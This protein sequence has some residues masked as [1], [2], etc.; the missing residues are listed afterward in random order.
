MGWCID[1]VPIG[2]GN[3]AGDIPSHRGRRARRFAG[4]MSVRLTP[5]IAGVFVLCA[6]SGGAGA[7]PA[8]AEPITTASAS[9]ATV[10]AD[11]ST[12]DALDRA[13]RTLATSAGDC[14]AACEAMRAIADARAKLC[15]PKSDACDDARKQEGEARRTTSE[16]CG[17]C[18]GGE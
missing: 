6:C 4:A 12:L 14:A 18:A 2:P 10:T 16:T 13:E 1:S 15:A 11:P 9:S 7:A 3:V 8:P 17:D 5:A